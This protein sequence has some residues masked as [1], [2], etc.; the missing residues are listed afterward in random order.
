MKKL[1]SLILALLLLLTSATFAAAE[2]G[3]KA[4]TLLCLNIGKAD[5][6]LLSW[7]DTH[8]LIDAG[9][10]ATF[11]ALQTA[12]SEYHIDRL[13]GVF[14]THCHD[15]HSGGLLPLAQTDIPVDA[16]YA[17]PH[18][19]DVKEKKHPAVL[20]AA[21]RGEEVTW[22]PAG[23]VLPVDEDASLTVLGPLQTDEDNENNNS[24]VLLFSSPAGSILLCGDM[25]TD[26]EADLVSAGN[27][28]ACTLLKAGHHGDD[29]TLSKSFLKAVR[30]EAAVISTSTAEE[31]DTPAPSTLLKLKNA[32]CAVY[33]TQD[34]HDAILFTLSGGK[35][36]AVEDIQ[37]G[38]APSRFEGLTLAIDVAADTVTLRNTA[39]DSVSLDGYTLYSTK[40]DESLRLTGPTLGPGEAWVIGSRSAAVPVDQTWE[41]KRVW[42]N[43]KTDY[44]ILY[45]PWGRPVACADNGLAD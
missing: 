3:E 30:P 34:C 29:E 18:F 9:Y 43:K 39:S 2:N 25:K 40:G 27:L 7:G 13:N 10:E 42:S 11:P 38:G 28:S 12:L 16:W 44:G 5:C 37:W 17:S 24:L 14:L 32:G 1:F 15:D 21:A 6:L 4:A 8:W 45:D 33:V 26:E 35:V 31:P 23:S 22:L 41:E 19:F 36:T 20:A